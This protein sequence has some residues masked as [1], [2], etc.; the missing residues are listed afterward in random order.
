MARIIINIPTTRDDAAEIVA[1]IEGWIEP[2]LQE[3][4]GWDEEQALDIRVED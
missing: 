3:A 4:L 2:Y 1:M